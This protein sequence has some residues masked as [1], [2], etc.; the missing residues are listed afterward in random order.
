MPDLDTRPQV[1]NI[2]HYA[3][4]TLTL[5]VKVANP[6]VI[7]GRVFK[8]QVRS[9]PESHRL[10]A[11]FFIFPNATGADVVLESPDCQRLA[12]RGK[13]VG[14]WDVQLADPNGLDSVVTLAYG[15]FTVHTDVTRVTT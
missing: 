1:V 12:K 8:A 5:H 14:H 4:D 11:E 10:D 2:N 15:T 9:R 7:A 3:G 13:Y 6:T